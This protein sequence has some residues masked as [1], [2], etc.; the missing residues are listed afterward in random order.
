MARRLGSATFAPG[1]QQP[2][3]NVDCGCLLGSIALALNLAGKERDVFMKP[4]EAEES[5]AD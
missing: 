3:R 1:G 4:R 2:L 5:G